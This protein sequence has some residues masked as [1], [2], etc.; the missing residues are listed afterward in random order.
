M[1]GLYN[2]NIMTDVDT[3]VGLGAAEWN[4]FYLNLRSILHHHNYYLIRPHWRQLQRKTFEEEE[5]PID[6]YEEFAAVS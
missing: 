5:N 6:Y 2:S 4:G 1:K 3:S